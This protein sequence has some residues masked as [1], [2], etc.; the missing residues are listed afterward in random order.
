MDQ[1]QIAKKL[2]VFLKEESIMMSKI[3]DSEFCTYIEEEQEVKVDI[4]TD[5]PSSPPVLL[6]NEKQAIVDEQCQ[7]EHQ[8]IVCFTPILESLSNE[9]GLLFVN[10][11]E[12]PWIRTLYDH[13]VKYQK[14]DGFSTPANL[15]HDTG[16]DSR[17]LEDWKS[18]YPTTY[19]Y[20]RGIW[21]I[22]DSYVLWEFKVRISPA[23]RGK[24]YSY[25][26]HMCRNDQF[27]QY[28]C[29]LCDQDSFYI[30]KAKGGIVLSIERWEWTQAGSR[31][32]LLDSLSYRN[33]WLK[34]ST[35]C[36]EYLN[37]TMLNFLGSGGY[38]RVFRVRDTGAANK[39]E[40]ESALKIALTLGIDGAMKE[41]LI[42]SE[43]EK[44]CRLK[45]LN[46]PHVV[47]VVK[48]SLRPCMIDGKL[49]GVGYLL[50]TVGRQITKQECLNRNFCERFFNSLLIIHQRNFHHGDA[51]F[52][53]A[54][55]SENEIYWIDFVSISLYFPSPEQKRRDFNVLI[56]SIFDHRPSTG[57]S[58]L[59]DR[60]GN[61]NNSKEEKQIL[62]EILDILFS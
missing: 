7:N 52:N 32:A 37:V 15:Y 6:A 31:R 5:V 17:D 42:V 33:K 39:V 49:I 1:I 12:L 20:G 2:K 59:L 23:D 8:L 38:G 16:T 61:S 35:L 9:C 34:L 47:H 24:A 51:R 29:I 18:R 57:Y 58:H 22:R 60:Y 19:R 41:Q 3:T 27:N 21:E 50:S 40:C 56:A 55:V 10:S 53:N 14:P 36:T 11:E 13:S 26:C 43:Y 54:I 4:K 62:S 46:V 44:L 45:N 30:I 28:Q 25:L 48:D